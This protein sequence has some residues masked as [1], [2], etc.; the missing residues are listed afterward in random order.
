MV[1]AAVNSTVAILRRC[2]L[3]AGL[4]DQ[5]LAVIAPSCVKRT[6]PRGTLLAAEGDEPAELFI[7]L[8]G[9]V[10][11]FSASESGAELVHTHITAG[12]TIGELSVI[13]GA[14][15][16]ASVEVIDRAMILAV[17]R[18]RLLEQLTSSSEALQSVIQHLAAM[19]RRLTGS[20]AD[21]VFLDLG[22]RLAKL[23]LAQAE[24][25]GKNSATAIFATSQSGL[26]DQLGVSRQSVNQALQSLAQEGLVKIDGRAVHV[27]NTSALKAFIEKL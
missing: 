19:V 9:R 26:A 18:D 2:E 1:D 13:D 16:S 22:R 8:S 11:V 21:L 24:P 12:G 20:A 15:R 6:L 3:L 5:A 17:P 4:S 25:N 10:R 23:V 7:V 27:P 14:A